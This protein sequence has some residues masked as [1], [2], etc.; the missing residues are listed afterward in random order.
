MKGDMKYVHKYSIHI[1]KYF[2]TICQF[3][4][5]SLLCFGY[6][7]KLFPSKLSHAYMSIFCGHYVNHDSDCQ[8]QLK[9]LIQYL[10]ISSIFIF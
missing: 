8:R 10:H 7:I 4:S 3:S 6:L 5:K 1:K 2:W 9:L